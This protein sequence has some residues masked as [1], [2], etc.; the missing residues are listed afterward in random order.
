MDELNGV[1]WVRADTEHIYIAPTRQA[2]D[3]MIHLCAKYSQ[4]YDLAC[5]ANMSKIVLS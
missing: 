1:A 5:N 4:V 3:E 2:L